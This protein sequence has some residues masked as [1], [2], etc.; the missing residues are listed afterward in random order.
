MEFFRRTVWEGQIFL[1]VKNGSLRFLFE[2]KGDLFHGR[3]FEMLS[4]LNQHCRPNTLSNAFSSLLS[5]FN[6]VQG[7]NKPILE[8]RS[9]FDGLILDMSRCK[10][11]IPQILLVMLFLRALN[12][13]Y[14]TIL[15]QFWSCFKSL[16]LAT[17]DSVVEDVTHHDS[18]MVVDN[19]KEK[20]HPPPAGRIPA[21]ASAVKDPKGTVYNSPFDWLVKWGHKGIKTRWT[22][23]L[24]GKGLCPICHRDEKPWHIPAHYPLLKELNLKLILGPPSSSAPAPAQAPATAAPT[25]APSPGGR[26][27]VTDGS[28]S[29]DS[30]GSSIAPSGMTTAL[31]TVVEYDPDE[32]FCWAGD[33]EGFGYG[34]VCPSAKSNASVALFRFSIVQSHSGGNDVATAFCHF[35]QH[36]SLSGFGKSVHSTAKIPSS[37]PWAI[38]PIFY[39][40]HSVQQPRCCRHRCHGSHD[41]GQVSL[42]ILQGHLQVASPHGE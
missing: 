34:S 41:T 12:S 40:P 38:I 4:T 1:A 7:D 33:E 29:T 5:L 42:Y 13:R 27:A 14:S 36:S 28:I 24:T 19:K 32:D 2:N 15:D 6:E 35:C 16:D 17:I 8:Y 18:F 25:P 39:C 10:V 30:S 31:D 11:A 20:K 9:C 21:A 3:G 22:W 23:A 26:V 37:S